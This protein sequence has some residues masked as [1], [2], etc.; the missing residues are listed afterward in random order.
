[1]TRPSG[2]SETPSGRKGWV[3]NSNG[4]PNNWATN[5]SPSNPRLHNEPVQHERVPWKRI[6]FLSRMTGGEACRGIR[7]EHSRLRKPVL[8]QGEDTLPGDRPF[9][10][11]AA[12][13]MPPMPKHPI[14]EYAE[15]V[16]VP[17]YRVVVEVALYDRLEP[18]TG[19][20]HGIVHTLPQLRPHAFADR[21]APYRKPP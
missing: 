12:K 5:L 7:M 10:A 6:R 11:A 8:S 4:K 14:P 21:L 1:M 15:T 3:R 20:T 9:L 17:R 16:E 19:L 13:C 18:V 2:T